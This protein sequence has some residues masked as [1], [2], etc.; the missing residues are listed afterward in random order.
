MPEF[1]PK[2][3]LKYFQT[4]KKNVNGH[5]ILLTHEKTKAIKKT[6]LTNF[7]LEVTEFDP[8]RQVFSYFSTSD[9]NKFCTKKKNKHRKNG[10]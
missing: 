7:D 4:K 9:C 1:M 5:I 6:R 2:K 8:S 10:K 3:T